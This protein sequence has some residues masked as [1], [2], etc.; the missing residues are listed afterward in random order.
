MVQPE[1]IYHLA[2]QSDAVV[3]LS[4]PC[5]T[6]F[7]NANTVM[8]L[9]DASQKL[10]YSVKIF[11]ANSVEI[12]KGLNSNVLLDETN[13]A[14]YPKN[15]YAIGKLAA[16]WT[17]RYY[18]ET[19]NEHMSNGL[20]FNAE[21]PRRPSRYVTQKITQWVKNG[22]HDC[23]EIGDLN[24]QCDWI[25]ASDVA[26][27]AYTILQQPTGS[28]YVI[29]LGQPHTVREFITLCL[30][31]IGMDITWLGTGLQE[32]GLNNDRILIKVNP[33]YF[34]PYSSPSQR[35]SNGKLLTTGWKPQYTFEELIDDLIS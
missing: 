15:P 11:Q 35:W 29:N 1:E 20:I 25:H 8:A 30:N 27:A 26:L 34:R 5:L 3:S 17:I 12:F 13:L 6:L 19:Y 4:N 16:Y 14:V 10:P 22:V 23:L 28:D 24:A 7:T 31:K 9:C 18:R 33:T 21:S 2:A 32:Q